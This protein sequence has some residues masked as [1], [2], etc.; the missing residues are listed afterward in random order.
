MDR[1]IDYRL[2]V[3]I[4]VAH[5][6]VYFTFDFTKVFWY[7][8]TAT[9]L[10]LISYA[11]LHEPMEDKDSLPKYLFFGII[12]GVATFFIFYLGNVLIEFFNIATVEKQISKLYKM[13]TPTLWWH[14]IVL[15]LIIVPGEEIFWR[16]F[17]QKRL[18]K[19]FHSWTSILIASTLYASVHVWSGQ[20][21]LVFAAFV[22]GI[23]FGTLYQW[24]KSLPF[25]IIAH[26]TFDLLL[27][28]IFP[29]R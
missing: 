29:F 17:V 25:V 3:G 13:A 4:L 12:F 16:G 1:K 27:F 21:I 26:L 14:F 8:F 7:I 23:I 19:I 9:M 2:I 15:V 28:I 18:M 11:I 10:F 20:F 24:R 22:A 6:L 5:L